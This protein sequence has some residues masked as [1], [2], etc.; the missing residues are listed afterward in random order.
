M[1]ETVKQ[2]FES[3]GNWD[4]IIFY[5]ELEKAPIQIKKK[6][7]EEFEKKYTD[8]NWN[9][10]KFWKEHWIDFNEFSD[11]M[12]T[13][14][15][16]KK[17]LKSANKKEVDNF[18]NRDERWYQASK[19]KSGYFIP[20]DVRAYDKREAQK[21]Y[22]KSTIDL[23]DKK[24]P[25]GYN[26]AS[27]R[28]GLFDT[29]NEM[30]F[31]ENL[32]K[33][34]VSVKLNND[35]SNIIKRINIK[36]QEVWW[37]WS[38]LMS[39][40]KWT[41]KERIWTYSQ[42]WKDWIVEIEYFWDDKKLLLNWYL[43]SNFWWDW[44]NIKTLYKAINDIWKEIEFKQTPKQLEEQERYQERMKKIIMYSTSQ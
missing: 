1:A 11:F 32:K 10:I 41:W 43:V 20:D 23:S 30:T 18:Y 26:K 42:N 6:I 34:P 44:L 24:W 4:E 39:A 7:A 29:V 12:W 35:I 3:I 31:D 16:S 37:L 22:Q 9:W 2:I 13:K 40:V 15:E 21:N 17:S 36:S 28:W 27:W 33:Y 8:K 25:K 38:W 14:S 19:E 5:E